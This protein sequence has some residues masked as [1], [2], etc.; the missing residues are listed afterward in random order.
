MES[1]G[2]SMQTVM[3]SESPN[4][5]GSGLPFKEPVQA[6]SDTAD[7]IAMPSEPGQI[8]RQADDDERESARAS[9]A[10]RYLLKQIDSARLISEIEAVAAEVSD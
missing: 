7:P 8:S 6:A 1:G 5:A 2:L 4:D 10:R 3:T 9:G